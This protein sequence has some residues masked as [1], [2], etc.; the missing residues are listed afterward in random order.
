MNY[1]KVTVS[2]NRKRLDERFHEIEMRLTRLKRLLQEHSGDEFFVPGDVVDL[3]DHNLQIAI[4]A[5]LD[6][7][8]HLVSVFGLDLPK[9]DKKEIFPILAKEHIIDVNLGKRL[10][11][12]AG[13]RNVLV[14]EY[15]KI[16][17]KK[18]YAAI[19]HNLG[20]I[21]EFVAQIQRFMDKEK[22]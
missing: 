17:R 21:E 19:K 10:M 16:I 22:Q 14:H 7:A 15:T 11:S 13:M 8:D 3:A 12:M 1:S 18:V 4:Q 20:D 6:I 2:I 9:E 5:C